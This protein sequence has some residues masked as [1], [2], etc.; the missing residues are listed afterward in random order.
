[1]KLSKNI[2][3]L[4]PSPTLSLTARAK[5]MK[6]KGRDIVGFGAGEPDFDT[7][8]FIKEAAKKAIDEG[9][10]KYTPASGIGELKKAVI[11]KFKRDN[12]LYYQLS[13]IIISCGAKHALFNAVLALCNEGD[14]VIIPSPYWVSYPQMVRVAGAKPVFIKTTQKN[15]FKITSGQLK[16]AITPKTKLIILNSPSNPT[17]MVYEE[18]ELKELAKIIVENNIFCIWDEIYEKIIY[19]DTKHINIA[20]L[21]EKIKKLT[22]VVNGVSKAY[23]MTGWRIG[24]AAAEEKIIKAMGNLQSHSTSNP[25]SISQKAALAALEASDELIKDRIRQ[26]KERRD[27]IFDKINSLSPLS[28]LKPQGAFY[29]FVNISPLFGKKYK[30]KI[31]TNSLTFSEILLEEAEVAVVAGSAFGEDNYIRIS[32]ATSMDN[33]KKG[34]KKIENFIKGLS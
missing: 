29:V 33:I 28:C 7:P 21:G 2:S 8:I 25:T 6:S 11:E 10:T 30:D 1:M 17:G 23:S 31:I 14:E 19:D 20:S 9:F 4:E 27:Y 15:N 32:Y 26:F 16:S 3:S 5:E 18:R 12:N 13:E 22:I 34:L 24:Y